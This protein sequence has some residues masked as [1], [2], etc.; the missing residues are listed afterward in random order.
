MTCSHSNAG[1]YSSLAPEN[2]I[3]FA[4]FLG[5]RLYKCP[6]LAGTEF[7]RSGAKLGQSDN[8]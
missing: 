3:P 6:E 2:L 8:H 7:Q 5:F 4:P 1:A